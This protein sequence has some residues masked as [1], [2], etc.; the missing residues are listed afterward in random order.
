MYPFSWSQRLVVLTFAALMWQLS[1]NVRTDF[2]QIP[3]RPM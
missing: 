2:Q 1:A 3:T